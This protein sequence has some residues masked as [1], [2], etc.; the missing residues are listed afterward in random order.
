MSV[1]LS[2]LGGN[3]IFSTLYKIELSFFVCTFLLYISICSTN[4][5]SVSLSVRLQKAK[6]LRYLWMLWSLFISFL[7][8]HL[9]TVNKL[10]ILSMIIFYLKTIS[11]ISLG[12]DL[13][14]LVID[15]NRSGRAYRFKLTDSQKSS[16]YKKLFFYA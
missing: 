6:E 13:V 11:T 9:F 2:G 10:Q 16:F 7:S 4:I 15:F 14:V 1:C 3:V 8:S 12:I 5:L